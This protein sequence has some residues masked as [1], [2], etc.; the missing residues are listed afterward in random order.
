M[1]DIRGLDTGSCDPRE[2]AAPEKEDW[3]F[4]HIAETRAVAGLNHEVGECEA[5]RRGI[6]SGEFGLANGTKMASIDQRNETL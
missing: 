2:L 4:A 6:T 1:G 5:E 3:R